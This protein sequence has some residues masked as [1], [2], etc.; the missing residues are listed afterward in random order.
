MADAVQP[1]EAVPKRAVD[2]YERGLGAAERQ[3]YD[4]AITLFLEA[5]KL[6]PTFVAARKKLREIEME[7]WNNAKSPAVFRKIVGALLSVPAWLAIL[8][9]ETYSQRGAVLRAYEAILKRDPTNAAALKGHAKTALRLDMPEVAVNSMEYAYVAN[10]K[11]E[12]NQR[13]MGEMYR[14]NGNV[15]EARRAYQ[16][17]LAKKPTDKEALK[18]M[19]DLAAL[20]TIS[21]GHWDDES[22]YRTK[23]KDEEEARLTERRLRVEKTEDDRTALIED[24][25]KRVAA[26]PENV[27]LTKRLANEY[28]EA[29][30]F[31]EAVATFDHAIK[32]NPGDP[33]LPELRY[34]VL[35]RKFDHQIEQAEQAAAKQP[36]D[37]A[38]AEA[39]GKIRHEKVRFMLGDLAA[40]VEKYPSNMPLR[41]EYGYALMQDEQI[42]EAIKQF[43]QSKSSAQ[44]QTMSLN[45]L[46]ECFRRKGLLDL[47]VDQFQAALAAMYTMDSVKKDVI[48]NLARTYEDMG[49]ADEALKQLKVIYAEDIGFRDVA[50]RVEK[51][52]KATEGEKP[53]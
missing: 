51:L 46:G 8:W 40:R 12:T 1:E 31:E 45:Y 41:F 30:R 5:L 10:P 15:E 9:N 36:D 47:A 17:V 27:D 37:Q 43:Q 50:K 7:K 18:A 33:D 6:A 3:N 26:N 21:R 44:K 13:L 39:V 49:K 42:D 14:A 11:S 23:I 34:R 28:L 48:Y 32:M 2:L 53:E 22:T 4:Y 19:H 24:Y 52:Y 38:L 29:D 35:V 20:G 25:K 16:K